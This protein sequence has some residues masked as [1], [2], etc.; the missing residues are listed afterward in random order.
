MRRLFEGGVYSNNYDKRLI[1]KKRM[2]GLFAERSG[3]FRDKKLS[4][5]KENE[6]TLEGLTVL[7][8]YQPLA[9]L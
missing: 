8:F 2:T 9:A 7:V 6:K 3:H 1:K 5:S 4:P